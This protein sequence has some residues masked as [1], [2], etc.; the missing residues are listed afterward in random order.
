MQSH[1][2]AGQVGE[3]ADSTRFQALKEFHPAGRG[4]WANVSD[5]N[6]ND[7]HWQLKN[8]I[9]SLEQLQLLLP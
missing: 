5:A 7:W 8:R 9:T 3:E 1:T 4:F 6:W 2:F